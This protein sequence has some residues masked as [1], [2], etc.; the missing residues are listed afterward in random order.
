ML[1]AA[2]DV[3]AEWGR[4]ADAVFGAAAAGSDLARDVI[5]AGGRALSAL[6][7]RLADRGAVVDDV[8]VAGG[9]VLNQ[10]ALYSALDDALDRDL[11]GTRLHP[12]RAR[13]G[14]RRTGP[15]SAVDRCPDVPPLEVALMDVPAAGRT[16]RDARPVPNRL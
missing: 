10:A 13:R 5:A 11:P 7:T 9:V 12:Q 15:R 1:D 14:C 6:V 3:S 2:A 8:V 16:A 4:H